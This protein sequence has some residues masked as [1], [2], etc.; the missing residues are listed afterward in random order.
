MATARVVEEKVYTKTEKVVLVMTVE[1]AKNLLG[2]IQ[3]MSRT[4][5]GAGKLVPKGP[6]TKA[7]C[8]ALEGK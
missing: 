3:T 2:Y 7:L 8:E 1:E 5:L 4:Q 6:V